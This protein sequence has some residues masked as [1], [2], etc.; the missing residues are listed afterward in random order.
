[1]N[2]QSQIDFKPL[3]AVARAHGFT[4]KR[5]G[6]FLD[7]LRELD[8]ACG[9]NKHA[10]V[11]ALACAC[12]DA[13]INTRLHIIEVLSLL[14]FNPRHVAITLNENTG[15]NPERFQWTRDETGAYRNT[16]C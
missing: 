14:G 5:W 10:R 8:T 15:T 11:S 3:P 13:G 12:I 1:M 9:P 6:K 2:M 4:A 7:G 16:E